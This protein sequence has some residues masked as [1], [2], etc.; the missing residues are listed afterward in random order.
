MA[1]AAAAP[2][3]KKKAAPELKLVDGVPYKEVGKSELR[4]FLGSAGSG[5]GQCFGEHFVG[6]QCSVVAVDA[7]K[8]LIEACSA[9]VWE[10]YLLSVVEEM[11]AI[12]QETGASTLVMCFDDIEMVTAA[13]GDTQ[14]TRDTTRMLEQENIAAAESVDFVS[15]PN[16]FAKSTPLNMIDCLTRLR[17][18]FRRPLT[19]WVISNIA[20]GKVFVPWQLHSNS[21]MIRV[22]FMGTSCGNKEASQRPI[23]CTWNAKE[24]APL[25]GCLEDST[26]EGPTVNGVHVLA[27]TAS[28]ADLAKFALFLGG[29]NSNAQ[30]STEQTSWRHRVLHQDERDSWWCDAVPECVML[31]RPFFAGEGELQ[32]FLM[33]SEMIDCGIINHGDS[34][35]VRSRDTDVMILSILWLQKISPRDHEPF[36]ELTWVYRWGRPPTPPGFMDITRF[37]KEML[38]DRRDWMRSADFF[39]ISFLF[40]GSDYTHGWFGVTHSATRRFMEK[41]LE[42]TDMRPLDIATDEGYLTFCKNLL[43]NC[44]GGYAGTEMKISGHSIEEI[45]LARSRNLRAAMRYFK[46]VGDD[47]IYFPA[48][49]D[50]EE[51]DLLQLGFTCEGNKGDRSSLRRLGWCPL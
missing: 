48:H 36:L 31:D 20:N 41:F 19:H 11:V 25:P 34:V 4:A 28:D 22:V 15:D 37:F 29:S 44:K 5:Y 40:A 21:D 32:M 27:E 39:L 12:Q 3:Q 46:A 45:C 42:E 24:M 43:K 17:W 26:D 38:N 2:L 33:L 35:Q 10:D 7:I 8:I 30:K 49:E 6:R 16:L 23:L 13:K 18:T 1:A 50:M 9:K 51:S 47:F 14:R